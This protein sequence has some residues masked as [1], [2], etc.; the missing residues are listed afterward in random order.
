[1]KL[2]FVMIFLL[3]FSFWQ[4]EWFK[5]LLFLGVLYLLVTHKIKYKLFL[6][7]AFLW[8]LLV[9]FFLSFFINVLWQIAGYGVLVGIDVGIDAI[10]DVLLIYILMWSV[11]SQPD[12]QKKIG[13]LSIILAFSFIWWGNIGWLEYIYFLV[14]F[15]YILNLARTSREMSYGFVTGY[16]LARSIF[17]FKLVLTDVLVALFPGAYLLAIICILVMLMKWQMKLKAK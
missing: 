12:W 16:F 13:L 7:R 17:D 15:Y 5:I 11:F 2:L 9:G 4:A 6:S 14:L 3:G 1:M 10:I 8:Q